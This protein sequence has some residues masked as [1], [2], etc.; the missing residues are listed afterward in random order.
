MNGHSHPA[1]VDPQPHAAQR[2]A[3]LNAI[4][5]ARISE[6]EHRILEQLARRHGVTLSEAV[7]AGVWNYLLSRGHAEATPWRRRVPL[8]E[9]GGGAPSITAR[10]WSGLDSQSDDQA[11]DWGCK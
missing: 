9:R 5:Q 4:L 2:R 3:P 1:A 10:R 8:S 7:R 6:P 11:D